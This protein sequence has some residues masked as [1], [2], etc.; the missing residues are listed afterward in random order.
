MKRNVNCSSPGRLVGDIRVPVRKDAQQRVGNLGKNF[1]KAASQ[2][3]E[4][5]LLM[6]CVPLDSQLADLYS[7]KISGP[8]LC[9]WRFDWLIFT[10]DLIQLHIGEDREVCFELVALCTVNYPKHLKLDIKPHL[11]KEIFNRYP[12]I[13]YY[14]TVPLIL[15]HSYLFGKLR[16]LKLADTKVSGF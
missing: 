15:D 6:N 11:R 16:N 14:W 12:P 2:L 1:F 4:G 3:S 8:S 7:R 13:A 5:W 10:I 9:F